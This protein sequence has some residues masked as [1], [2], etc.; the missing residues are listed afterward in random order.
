MCFYGNIKQRNT[1]VTAIKCLKRIILEQE[2]HKKEGGEVTDNFLLKSASVL[3]E[4][5]DVSS[6]SNITDGSLYPAVFCDV[7]CA[8]QSMHFLLH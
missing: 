7:Q 5:V 4:Y 1:S 8:W 6:V 2:K 3:G